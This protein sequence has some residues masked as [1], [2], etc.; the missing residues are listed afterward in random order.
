MKIVLIRHGSTD[1]NA[2]K[3]YI[4]STDEPLSEAGRAQVCDAGVDH[5]LKT[6]WVSTLKRTHETARL[7]FPNAQLIEEKAFDEMN[8]GTF[9]GK[10]YSELQ[11]NPDYTRWVEQG[12]LDPCPEG[13]SREEFCARVCPVFEKSV[14]QLMQS[15]AE[16]MVMVVHGG[17]IMAVLERYA[18]PKK[19]YFTYAPKNCRGYVCEASFDPNGQLTLSIDSKWE[20]NRTEI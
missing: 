3:R 15:G 17:T 4:G 20:H 12:C 7:L 16:Q 5:S 18:L 2:L 14:R 11:D 1:G 19:D 9:E 8:F 13:E 10:N 6:A